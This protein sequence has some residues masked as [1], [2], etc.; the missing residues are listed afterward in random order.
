MKKVFA[1]VSFLA[2]LAGSALPDAPP[3]KDSEFVFARV[4][5]NQREWRMY[6][7]EA[8]WHH[9]YPFSDEFFP[10]MLEE[11]TGIRTS[12]KAYH[13]VQL[14]S[15][16]IFNYPFLYVSEPGFFELNDKEIANLGEYVRRGGFIMLDDF[17]GAKWGQLIGDPE[18]LN[19]V[20][21]Y[22]KRALPEYDF[23]P[24]S[25]SH[26]VF[27]SFYKIDTLAMPPPYDLNGL[28]PEFW[29]LSDDHGTLRVIANYNNDLG[30]FWE[31][32]DKG[33]QPFHEAALSVKL[34]VNY[35][36]YAMTH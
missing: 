30:E 28:A 29:G 25:V 2:V 12:G 35:V 20:R 7:R 18:E 1:V 9:D 22:F 8:P 21:Y 19:I 26:P 32:V 27:N 31:W 23:V 16:E 15:P 13:I 11:V 5:S 36:V 6:W 34:G 4:E 3:P 24:L 17:R 14:D 33:E 10:D